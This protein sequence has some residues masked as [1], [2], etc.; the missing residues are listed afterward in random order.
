MFSRIGSVCPWWGAEGEVVEILEG[1]GVRRAKVIADGELVELAPVGSDE[2][3]LGDRVDLAW[4]SRVASGEPLQPF[5]C[6][7]PL[8]DD[9][10]PHARG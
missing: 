1:V 10:D 6:H 3:H 9:H 8:D 4:P 5:D 7:E 2:I